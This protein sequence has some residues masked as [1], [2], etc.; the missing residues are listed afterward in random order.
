MATRTRWRVEQ[1]RQP[2]RRV[3]MKKEHNMDISRRQCCH[4]NRGHFCFPRRPE[5]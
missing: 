2:V 4:T 5:S 1:I 3:H